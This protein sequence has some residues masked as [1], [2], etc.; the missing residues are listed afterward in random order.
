VENIT[1]LILIELKIILPKIQIVFKYLPFLMPT[2]KLHKKNYRWLTNVRGSVFA[3]TSLILTCAL[4][5]LLTLLN[6]WVK[7]ITNG[8]HIFINMKTSFWIVESIIDSII[9]ICEKDRRCLRR[10]HYIML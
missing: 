1:K 4:M 8:Y 5:K 6:E 2:Y 7:I 10:K 3:L 9:N